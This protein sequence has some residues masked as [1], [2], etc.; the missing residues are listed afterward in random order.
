MSGVD[1]SVLVRSGELTDMGFVLRLE[2]QCFDDPWPVSALVPE[3]E[4]NERVRPLVI[5]SE[6]LGVGYLMAWVVADEYHIV[7]LGIDPT[8]RRQGLASRLLE[9]GLAE[10]VSVDCRVATLEVRVSNESAR[11]FY[12][13]FGFRE[14]GRRPRY[15]A[16]NGEDALILTLVL[17]YD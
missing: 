8:L 16:D 5:L 7:N 1:E 2:Q 13:R 15:Y 4:R 9:A 6:G 14:V 3:L 10:A 17:T 11:T 12:E